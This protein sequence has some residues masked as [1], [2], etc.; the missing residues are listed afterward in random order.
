MSGVFEIERRGAVI[1]GFMNRPRVHNAL[2]SELR[3]AL[4]QFWDQVKGDD[5]IRVA[6]IAGVPGASFGSGRDM[7]ETYDAYSA[8][9]TGADWELTNRTGY[10]VDSPTGKPVIAAIDGYCLGAGL[11]VA[12]ECDLR[13]CTPEAVFASPQAKV[14]RA[15][16]S[17]LYL[18][19]AGVPKAVV[20]DMV[21]TGKRLG[22]AEALHYG[23]VSRVVGREQLIEEAWRMAETI[24]EMSPTVISGLK[25]GIDAELAEMPT[26][27]G[28]PLWKSLTAM[29]GD[30]GDARLGAEAF[31]TKGRGE[32]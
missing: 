10:P 17:P 14:G 28:S 4:I 32:S 15:T 12:A 8:G 24:A 3:E 25:K 16:E 9:E 29:Y 2:N 6:I 23:L 1:A 27:I 19:K 7:K 22:G 31:V 11:K 13:I 20:F 18:Q 21:F 26:A 30:T 5:G